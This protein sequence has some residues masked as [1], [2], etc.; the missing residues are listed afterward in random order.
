MTV[1]LE[2]LTGQDYEEIVDNLEQA[3]APVLHQAQQRPDGGVSIVYTGTLP[4]L[5]ESHK[6]IMRDLIVSFGS[7]LLLIGVV[8]VVGLRS[9]RLGLV[10]ILPNLFPIVLVFG[11]LGWL[12]RSIDVGTMMTASV[13]L[14]IAVDGTVHYLTWFLRGVNAG[15]SRH[16]A[17]LDAYRH[18]ATAMLRSSAICGGGLAVYGASSFLPAARFGWI[19][20]ALLL[21]ALVG[22]LLLLPALLAG[23]LGKILFPEN[24]AN[25][26][27]AEK[28]DA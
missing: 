23:R 19:I 18:C 16:A 28:G 10:S 9:V 17:I 22:D 4:L 13:G 7:S 21:T 14:G 3:V 6:T 11:A 2:G 24:G 12:G 25:A 26:A 15:L 8:L 5:A 27:V 20:C 1:R